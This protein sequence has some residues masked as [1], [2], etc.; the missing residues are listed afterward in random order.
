MKKAFN[1]HP[2]GFNKYHIMASNIVSEIE[3]FKLTLAEQAIRTFTLFF[4]AW[5]RTSKF[6]FWKVTFSFITLVKPALEG[7]LKL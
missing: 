5:D 3:D 2:E 6:S 4:I 7:G 1:R